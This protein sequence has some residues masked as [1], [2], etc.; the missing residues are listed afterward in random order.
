M[1]RG[2]VNEAMSE[3]GLKQ[4]FLT[5]GPAL[6]RYLLVRGLSR[7]DAED[8]L[9]DLYIKLDSHHGGPVDEPRAY[10][11][12]MA[13]NL[14]LDRRRSQSRRIRRE[15]EWAGDG[16]GIISD[17][18]DRP[19]AEDTLIARERLDNMTAALNTLPE[20]T[21]DIFRRFRIEEQT[22]KAIAEDLG[23][24]KSAVEK[25]IYRAYRVVTAAREAFDGETGDDATLSRGARHSDMEDRRDS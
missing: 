25:H 22:Q 12:R 19:S 24:S 1:A 20:R 15:E 5:V 9:Q 11:Y 7:E 21:R 3:S 4:V 13:H 2:A 17:L 23:L 18:D 16:T 8:L 6:T 10:L 14:L